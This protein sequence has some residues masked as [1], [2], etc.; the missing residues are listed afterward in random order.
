MKCIVWDGTPHAS[1]CQYSW[2]DGSLLDYVAHGNFDAQRAPPSL[3]YDK[4]AP[5]ATEFMAFQ[6]ARHDSETGTTPTIETIVD[7]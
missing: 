2:N 3:G 5:T 6:A 1:S 4:V 7:S